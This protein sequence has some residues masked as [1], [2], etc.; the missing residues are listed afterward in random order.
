MREAFA[1][2]ERRDIGRLVEL[3]VPEILL[4]HFQMVGLARVCE[5]TSR[6][7]YY[8]NPRGRLVFVT[9]VCV[10]HDDTPET[11]RPEAFPLIGN[12]IDLV[13][14]DERVPEQWRLR[15]GLAN[16]LGAIAPQYLGLRPVPIWKS[17]LSWLQHRCVGLVPLSHDPAEIRLLLACCLGGTIPEKERQHAAA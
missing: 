15:T 7:L 17:P 8:P 1:A 11:T 10:H 14:W 5:D 9:P 12:L 16:W 13:A 6:T 4:S 2:M 3:G